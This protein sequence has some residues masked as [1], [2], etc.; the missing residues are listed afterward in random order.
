MTRKFLK[1]KGQISFEFMMMVGFAILIMSVL[2]L[3]LGKDIRDANYQRQYQQ[4]R[5]IGVAVQKEFYIAAQ[6]KEGYYREFKIPNKTRDGVEFEI[7][8]TK[9]TLVLDTKD[10]IHHYMILPNITGDIIPGQ[11]NVINT[12]SGV[13]RLN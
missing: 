12:S 2:L 8:I 7:Y 1:K 5:D 11:W 4:I 10:R 6:V 9:N 13:I 3:E